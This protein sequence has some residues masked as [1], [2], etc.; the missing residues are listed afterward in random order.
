MAGMEALGREVNVI[1]IGAGKGFSM[2]NA[3]A[4]LFVCTGNDTFTLTKA[5]SFAGSYTNLAVIT[6]YYTNTAT[7]GTAAWVAA[8]QAAAATVTQSSGTTVFH[9]L[10]SQLSDPADYL[11]VTVGASG[12]VAVFL[13]DMTVQRAPA[14]LLTVGA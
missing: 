2:K 8:T 11:K 14:N 10:T 9:V 6:R 1:P 5:S 4:V 12:L 7:N 3:S 13:Y